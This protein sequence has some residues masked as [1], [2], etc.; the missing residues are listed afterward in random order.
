[1][2]QLKRSILF[3]LLLMT[4][5]ASALAQ[6]KNHVVY[7]S[8]RKQE[9]IV[10]L[11]D[12]EFLE[13]FSP[14]NLH[15]ADEYR[16]YHSTLQPTSETDSLIKELFITIVLGT[17][18]GDSREQLPRFFRVTDQLG[19]PPEHITLIGVDG[20]KQSTDP[21][22]TP[23]AIERVPT[24]IFTRNCKELGRIIETP[25]KSLEEDLLEIIKGKKP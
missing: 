22:V 25:Q 2:T 13:G 1:M 17:W 9:V 19:I 16:S 14:F 7:D 6:N 23:M 5:A 15:Y 8:L 3:F 21:D 24:F 11:C 4:T 18:C 10:G 20:R 12:R